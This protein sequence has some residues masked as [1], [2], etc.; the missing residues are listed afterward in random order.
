MAELAH[1]E[2]IV[3]GHVQGVF[4][5]VFAS[6][7]AKLQNLKGYVHNLPHGNVQVVAEGYRDKLEEFT[8]QLRQGPPE[9]L[10]DDLKI[11]WSEF[12]GQYVNF[13]IR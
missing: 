7:I 1:V 8:V 5:R 12:T 2:V 10:V 6:R 9:A 4:F 13:E 3:S 11:Q